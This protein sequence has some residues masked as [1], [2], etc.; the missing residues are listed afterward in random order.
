MFMGQ[1]GRIFV[2]IALASEPYEPT[3]PETALERI[4]G[5]VRWSDPVAYDVY[6]PDGTLLGRVRVRDVRIIATRGDRVWAIQQD[7]DGVQR[8]KGF[9]IEWSN[10]RPGKS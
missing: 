3:Q 6:E 1:D 5:I 4:T 9:H 7:A 8:V 10:A 2:Q